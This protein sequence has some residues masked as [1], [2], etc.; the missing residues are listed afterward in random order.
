M[1]KLIVF[2]IL[3]LVVACVPCSAQTVR[4]IDLPKIV[5]PA[6]LWANESEVRE[7][8][9]LIADL[10]AIDKQALGISERRRGSTFS[11]LPGV[12]ESH[13]YV[14]HDS[15]Y[16]AIPSFRRLVELGPKSLPYLIDSL[17]DKTPTKL[18]FESGSQF[19]GLRWG[20]DIQANPMNSLEQ[21]VLM[22]HQ[23]PLQHARRASSKDNLFPFVADL[24]ELYIDSYVVKVGDVCLVAIGEITG[25]HYW[26][27]SSFK[28]TDITSP[29]HDP[30]ICEIIRE[31]WTSD[32]PTQKL[33]GSLLQDYATRGI[34][35]GVSLS[36]WIKGSNFQ[37]AASMRLLY[38]FPGLADRMIAE[39]LDSLKSE[40]CS[41]M[42]QCVKDDVMADDFV[43]AVAWSNSSEIQA[44]AQRL[45]QRTV[46]VQ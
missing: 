9:S 41:D 37:C 23:S 16:E 28:G 36:G 10:S 31:I 29:T 13:L 24:D 15:E 33:F 11:P 30:E 1:N 5:P 44:A 17:D 43:K 7:I 42:L 34:F 12:N 25:R 22:D 27:V 26:A 21:R 38:Y 32:D 40:S 19:F 2:A 3:I 18:H 8:K 45:R 4:Q 46:Q 35:N 14:V 6:S 20:R 39:R